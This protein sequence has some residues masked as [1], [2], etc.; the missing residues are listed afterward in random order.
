LNNTWSPEEEDV[1]GVM[2][3]QGRKYAVNLLWLM[4]GEDEKKVLRQRRIRKAQADF[5]CM[6][7]HV[8]R[9]IGF[10]WL[11]RGHR[12]NMP[13]AA[14]IVADQLV[15]EWHGV[16]QADNGWWYMQVHSDAIAPTGDRFFTAESD[17]YAIF[18]ENLTKHSWSHSYAPVHWNIVES[19]REMTL[20]RLMDDLPSV[21]LQPTSFVATVGGKQNRS[22]LLGGI[23]TL[24][25]LLMAVYVFS[26]LWTQPE[27]VISAPR[28]TP[29]P[30]LQAPKRD[31]VELP[32]PSQIINQCHEASLVLFKPLPG[33]MLKSMTCTPETIIMVW[34]GDGKNATL[35]QSGLQMVPA[36]GNVTIT[37]KNITVKKMLPRP[38]VLVQDKLYAMGQGV[39]KLQE[40]LT[41][42]GQVEIKPVT[43][44]PPPPPPRSAGQT[45]PAPR[46]ARPY[47]DV[48]LKTQEAMGQMKRYLDLNGLSL[49]SVVWDIPTGVWQYNMKVQ[50]ERSR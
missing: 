2:E 24:M 12:R 16:F 5:Y 3:H 41:P 11:S 47:L 6:R 26:S 19:S 37:G 21:V 42:Y 27:Q 25:V 23:F 50:L 34:E 4:S 46:L 33:W 40:I 48:T 45:A 29:I 30:A 20:A 14:T 13:V 22:A 7:T 18:H 10:G 43:P 1:P 9:Q 15:G 38:P 28:N 44:A 31:V 32:L 8:S 17:A 36:E 39:M 35:A 49:S